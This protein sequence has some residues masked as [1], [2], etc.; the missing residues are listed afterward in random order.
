MRVLLDRSH[1]TATA[2]LS[3]SPRCARRIRWWWRRRCAMRRH[4]DC[5]RCCSRRPA[6]RSTRTAATPACARRTSCASCTASPRTSVRSGADRARRRSPRPQP[7]DR[8]RGSQ[9][10]WTRPRRWWRPSSPPAP[11]DPPRL[12]DVPVPATRCRCPRPR[13]S[14]A[15]CGCA[16]WRR[17]PGRSGRRGTGVCG[18]APKC[19]CRAGDR[20]DPCIG[21][22]H[23]GSGAGHH[24]RA[25][26]CLRRGGP[27]RRHGRAYRVGRA[28]GREFDHHEVIDYAPDKARALSDA[29]ARVPG[30]VY[31]AHSTDYQTR[32]ALAA[33]CATTSRSSR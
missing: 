18:S 16:G 10:R 23:A 7:M 6:T 11:K 3:A 21:G 12:L 19:R 32:T 33:L 28:A 31:E 26:R 13:S 8:T 14:N 2:K 5:R 25:S 15:P 24:R 29:I 9:K 27:G 17:R 1:A 4:A 30:M 22:D 20:G